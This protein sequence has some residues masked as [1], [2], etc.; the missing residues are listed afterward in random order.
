LAAER[1]A[2]DLVRTS[3][4]PD[5][6][7]DLFEHGAGYREGSVTLGADWTEMGIG[8]MAGGRFTTA[9]EQMGFSCGL[10]GG[11]HAD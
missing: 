9:A 5:E 1:S 6:R 2:I 11:T 10:H 8:E 3:T 7:A 4:D